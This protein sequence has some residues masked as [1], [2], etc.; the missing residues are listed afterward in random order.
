MNVFIIHLRFARFIY[1]ATLVRA[2]RF[3]ETFLHKEA[4]WSSKRKLLL[5]QI[6]SSFW[7]DLLL[8]AS[9]LTFILIFPVAVTSRWHLSGFALRQL[10]ENQSKR[11]SAFFL[12]LLQY[13]L[14]SNQEHKVWYHL[15]N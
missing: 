2:F 13:F 10:L 11:L 4:T 15:H 3:C 14:V 6:P 1:C 8:I 7:F 12:A 5:K 9:F